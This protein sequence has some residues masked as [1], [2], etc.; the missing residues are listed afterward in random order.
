MME[1]TEEAFMVVILAIPMINFHR[2][3]YFT[4]EPTKFTKS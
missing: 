1:V 2:I 4:Y 3:G